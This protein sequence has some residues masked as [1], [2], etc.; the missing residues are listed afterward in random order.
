MNFQ[1]IGSATISASGNVQLTLQPTASPQPAQ[2]HAV[3]TAASV[4]Q[5][6]ADGVV[7]MHPSRSPMTSAILIPQMNNV[8]RGLR[9]ASG[10]KG[11][12]NAE[13]TRRLHSWLA[14]AKRQRANPQPQLLDLPPPLPI[15]PILA[16]QVPLADEENIE[17][18]LEEKGEEEEEEEDDENNDD[19]GDGDSDNSSSSSSSSPSKSAF[20]SLKRKVKAMESKVGELED[21]MYE[22]EKAYKSESDANVVLLVENENLRALLGL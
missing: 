15:S 17:E 6:I 4:L 19:G 8:Q 22:M 1:I 18:N 3:P 2:F 21:G 11:E 5:D 7:T 14:A 9:L 16:A 20:V 10:L 13:A 12:W